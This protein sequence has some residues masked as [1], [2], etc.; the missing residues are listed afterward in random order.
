M[1]TSQQRLFLS[2]VSPRICVLARTLRISAKFYFAGEQGVY[3]VTNFMDM[4]E[5]GLQKKAS[6]NRRNVLA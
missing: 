6:L 4:V 5:V 1:P 3:P 2:N